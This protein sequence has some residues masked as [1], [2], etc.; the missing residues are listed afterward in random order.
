M[1]RPYSK[2]IQIAPYLKK[3]KG[4]ETEELLACLCEDGSVW[5]LDPT[6]GAFGLVTEMDD[7]KYLVPPHEG[8]AE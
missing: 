7:G 8:G 5:L 2:I 3:Y 6:F 1:S 4:N